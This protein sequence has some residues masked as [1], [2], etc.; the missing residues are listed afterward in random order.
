MMTGSPLLFTVLLTAGVGLPAPPSLDARCDVRRE[1]DRA[2]DAADIRGV[3][4]SAA[5]G[6]L[7]VT[8]SARG[9]VRVTAVVCASD[10]GLAEDA[11]LVAEVRRGAAWIEADLSDH[12]G[13]WDRDY[14][15]MD[16]V[17]EMPAGLAA[18]IRDGSGEVEVAGIA[19]VRIEDGS[20]PIEVEDIE[21][22]V[23][24]DDG[25]GDVVLRRVG[26]VQIEDGSGGIEI[27]DVRGDVHVTEDGSG[28][29]DIREVAGSVRIDDDGTGGIYV[30]DVGGDLV[31]GDEGSGS[32]RYRDVRGRVR[33][34]D[35]G[36]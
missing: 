18:D 29:I 8:G 13:G 31:V 34:P 9:G 15:R 24:I 22:E 16:L 3:L 20:G 17:I 10:E 23:E 25:S 36:R 32:L 21:G 2:L 11:R 27:A 4:V 33:V 12:D 19:A 7:R 14:V 30:A 6:S 28:G 5:A 1:L 35:G 26:A